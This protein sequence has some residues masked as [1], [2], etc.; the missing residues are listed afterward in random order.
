MSGMLQSPAEVRRCLETSRDFYQPATT[1][2]LQIGAFPRGPRPAEIFRPGFVDGFDE[3][4]ELWRRLQCLEVRDRAIL[5][6]W[7][8]VGM[9]PGEVA[10]RVGISRRHC[11]RRRSA[12]IEEVVRLGEPSR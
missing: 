7:H 6:L 5:F 12:A 1:S 4:M 8:V 2:L 10:R 9:P 3:R 11:F